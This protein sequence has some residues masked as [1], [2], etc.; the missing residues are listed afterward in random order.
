MGPHHHV[1]REEPNTFL[2]FP[3]EAVSGYLGDGDARTGPLGR[4]VS[5][6]RLL[7]YE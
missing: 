6:S 5:T 3:W 4:A 2:H 1:Q 7:D